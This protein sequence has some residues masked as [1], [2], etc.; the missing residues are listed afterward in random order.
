MFKL[1]QVKIREFSLNLIVGCKFY[2]LNISKR[3]QFLVIGENCF[4][5]TC[6]TFENMCDSVKKTFLFLIKSKK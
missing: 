5:F 4:L 2:K 1:T 3:N 6:V